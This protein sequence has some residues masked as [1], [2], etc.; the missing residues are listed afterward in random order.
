MRQPITVFLA[1]AEGQVVG[2]A[3]Y[4]AT[5]RGFFGPTGVA[6]S[7]RGSGIGKALLLAALWGLADLGYV[8]A[9]IG[10]AGPVEFYRKAVGAVVI[11]D[12]TP[13]SYTDMLR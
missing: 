11:P 5:R 4:E 9:I 8:Y 12:S 7:H 3:T 10:A 6:P 2:F 1:V 13:G